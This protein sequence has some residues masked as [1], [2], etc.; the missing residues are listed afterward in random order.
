MVW[1]CY[2]YVHRTHNR[3]SRERSLFP[4]MDMAKEKEDL[5]KWQTDTTE[6][7]TNAIMADASSKNLTRNTKNVTNAMLTESSNKTVEVAVPASE[8]TGPASRVID[9]QTVAEARDIAVE[10]TNRLVVLCVCVQ[11]G[12]SGERKSG[13]RERKGREFLA[14]STS[15]VSM[16][17]TSHSSTKEALNHAKESSAVNSALI[18]ESPPLSLASSDS[19]SN[20]SIPSGPKKTVTSKLTSSPKCESPC[21]SNWHSFVCID[22]VIVSV[23]FHV[24]AAICLA[25]VRTDCDVPTNTFD[26]FEGSVARM[27]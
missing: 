21:S 7:V 12:E 26:P 17:F 18:G 1:Y 15:A 9:N 20:E 25:D 27:K 5:E 2:I 11:W 14:I 3:P 4:K 13:E 6:N 8:N 16:S 10:D 23:G 19:G 22:E 24:T